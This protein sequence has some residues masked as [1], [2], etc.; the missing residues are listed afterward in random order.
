MSCIFMSVIFSAPFES[1]RSAM[2]WR[3]FVVLGHTLAAACSADVTLLAV[4]VL[5]AA[6]AP[7]ACAGYDRAMH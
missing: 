4:S 3:G 6:A 2:Q 1:T 7:G 5:P